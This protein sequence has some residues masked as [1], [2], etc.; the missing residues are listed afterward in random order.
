MV[1]PAS[2]NWRKRGGQPGD[3]LRIET[4]GGLVKQQNRR[5]VQQRASDRYALAHAAG[6][7]AHQRSAAFEQ[8]DFLQEFVDTSRGVGSFLQAREEQQIF[9][10]GELVVD[11]GGVGD[12]TGGDFGWARDAH[13]PGYDARGKVSSPEVGRTSPAAI[14]NK[15]VFP[16]PLRPAR[17]TH[18][19]GAN[20]KADAAQRGEPAKRFSIFSKRMPVGE[21]PA[22]CHRQ[23]SIAIASGRNG[24][25]AVN[26][27]QSKLTLEPDRAEL[28][29]RGP[30]PRRTLRR[31]WYRPGGAIPGG[32]VALSNSRGWWPRRR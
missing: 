21:K 9:F 14:R 12:E 8:A 23:T 31:R 25:L 4:G 30:A 22:R 17:A 13:A 11:H 1:Q 29:P 24:K 5:L 28:F 15:V 27:A 16:E 2:R 6:K 26:S 18:S 19:P 7:S 3:A 10:G 32:T 20:L